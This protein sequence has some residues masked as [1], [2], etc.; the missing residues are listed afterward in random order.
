[1]SPLPQRRKS[2][3]EISLLRESL[4]IPPV[5]DETE[6]PAPDHA[7]SPGTRA[8]AAPPRQRIDPPPAAEAAVRIIGAA[9]ADATIIADARLPEPEVEDKEPAIRLQLPP[10]I[11]TPRPI[12]TRA[13]IADLTSPIPSRRRSHEE[14]EE[15][16][17]R[18]ALASIG[19]T[20][21]HPGF[22]HA[23]PALI[24]TGYLLAFGC[25]GRLFLNDWPLRA[26][27]GCAAA[28]LVV[29]ACILILRPLSRHHAAF[30]AILC[31]LLSAFAT[32]QHVP[33]LLHAP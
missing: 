21:T 10:K 2:P 15:I 4:G 20:A 22:I 18:D 25:A 17:R 16:R 9:T 33:H 14:L 13:P 30:I 32:L 27:V 28:S 31:L 3:E 24:A 11:N 29:A 23:H 26:T 1:M 8:P 19:G 7:I 5:I 6:H 12:A